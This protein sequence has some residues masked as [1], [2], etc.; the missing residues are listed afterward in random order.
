MI[1]SAL[2]Q[3]TVTRRY[4][5]AYTQ[6]AYPGGDVPRDRGVCTDVVIRSMRA[7][8]IDLQQRVH[9]D[10]SAHFAAYPRAWGSQH[11]DPNIDH[12]RVPNLMTYFGRMGRSLPITA[13]PGDYLPGDVVA[14][15]LGNGLLHVGVITNARSMATHRLLVVHNIGAGAQLEDVLFAWRLVGHYRPFA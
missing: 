12:R 3:T 8:G 6:I 1:A 11:P 9:E 7:G 13:D 4:D 5:P 14:W 15:E 10:M 2:E